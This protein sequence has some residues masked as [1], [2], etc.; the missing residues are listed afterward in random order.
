[1]A[2]ERKVK[3]VME[4]AGLY[5]EGTKDQLRSDYIAEEEIQLAGKSYTLSK[6]SFL[7]AK[8]FTDELDTV[9]VQQNPL[10]HEIYAKNAVSMFDLV[11]MVNVN[12]KQGFKGALASGNELDFMLFSSRQFYDPDNSGTA[13]T[14]WVKSIS[15]VGSKNFFEG[16]STGVELT[17][18]EEEGQIWL[19]FYNPAATPCVDAFKVTMNTEP[20]DVQSLDFEQVGEH[21]GDVIVEL[22]EPWTLPPEQSGEIEAYYFRTGTDEM[23][24]LGIWVFMAKNMRDLTS[25]IP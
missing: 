14:S 15:S 10:I 9:L 13:R 1:M 17:M 8:I 7:D 21:E 11:R 16:G 5:K 22:K 2:Q 18:A 19:A 25:L 20:F 12:T 6:I 24:P 3:A 23:R 4:A